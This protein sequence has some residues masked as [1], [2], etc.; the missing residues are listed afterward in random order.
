MKQWLTT[1]IVIIV[2]IGVGAFG[3]QYV[4]DQQT[5]ISTDNATVQANLSTLDATQSGVLANWKIKEG[6]I[7]KQGDVVGKITDQTLTS[8]TNGTVVKTSV[9]A[10]QNVLQ[11]QTLAQIAD[12]DQS[13]VLAYIDEDQISRVKLGQD[14]KVTIESLS[15]DFYDGKVMEIGL[16]TGAFYNETET[17]SASSEQEVQRI[18]VK[19]SVENLPVNRLTLGVHAEVKIER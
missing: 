8:K 15:D 3:Y 4:S 19:I 18:P 10:R 13:Y 14:V 1:I 16:A 9:Y 7:V 5:Y 11:G 2:V 17:S 6:D 12:L